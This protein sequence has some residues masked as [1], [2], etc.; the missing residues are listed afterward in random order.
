MSQIQVMQAE[1]K[2]YFITEQNTYSTLAIY[3]LK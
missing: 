3:Y 1:H 2:M